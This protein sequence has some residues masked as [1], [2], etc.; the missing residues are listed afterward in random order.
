MPIRITL[1]Y[2]NLDYFKQYVD[3]KYN[4]K[5]LIY[6]TNQFGDDKV[7]VYGFIELK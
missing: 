7:T 3:A 6:I 4:L 2:D 5:Y 1:D